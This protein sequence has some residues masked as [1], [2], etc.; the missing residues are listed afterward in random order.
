MFNYVIRRIFQTIPALIGVTLVVFTL[1]QLSGDPSAVLLPP[2]ASEEHAEAFREAYGLNDPIP[3]QYF[4]Y[5]VNVA[6]LDFGESFT[7]GEPALN[8]VL[9]R[10]P[11]TIELTL[12]ALAIGVLIAVPAGIIAAIRRNS[13]IDRAVMGLVLVGQ[14]IPTFWLG[15]MLALLISVQLKVLPVSGRGS[16]QHLILPAFTLAMWVVALLGRVT[17]SEMLEVLGQD[18]VRT[19][20]SKGLKDRVVILRHALKNALPPIVTVGGLQFGA[21][22]SGAVMTERVFNWPGVGTLILDAI[23]MRDY[24]VV[25]A[26]VLIFAGVF[27]LINLILDVGYGYL[28]PRIRRS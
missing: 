13:L 4:H 18:F 22:L 1:L 8:V 19:A 24:P 26:G 15:M 25:V 21:M 5:M 16:F 10:M 14:S 3:I 11:A 27:I 20:R 2:E 12:A 6:Q 28:D 7:Y 17:R 23:L 9:R